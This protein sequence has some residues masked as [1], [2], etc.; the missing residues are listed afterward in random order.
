MKNFIKKHFDSLNKED[1]IFEDGKA[2]HEFSKEEVSRV[3]GTI[4]E[5]RDVY[6]GNLLDFGA[7]L[8]F[9]QPWYNPPEPIKS[10]EN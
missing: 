7:F 2:L 5:D 9:L 3:F 8:Y 10:Q 4:G 1:L 6:L